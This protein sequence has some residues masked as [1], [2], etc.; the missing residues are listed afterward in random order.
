[1]GIFLQILYAVLF[2]GGFEVLYCKGQYY[3]FNQGNKTDTKDCQWIQKL[4]T[5]GL[6]TSRF[7]DEVK[8]EELILVV[9]TEKF[10]LIQLH[11]LPKKCKNISACSISN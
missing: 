11:R 3:H 7:L 4:H 9:V 1:M 5:L 8:T 2:S 10:C 6:L